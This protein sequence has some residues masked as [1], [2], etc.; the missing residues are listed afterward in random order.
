[1]VTE[2]AIHIIA[3]SPQSADTARPLIAPGGAYP[4][5]S[6]AGSALR[7]VPTETVSS[8]HFLNQFTR[9]AAKG[10]DP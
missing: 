7:L 2:I 6:A 1:M 10:D 9:P 8:H 5:G 3:V 4:P